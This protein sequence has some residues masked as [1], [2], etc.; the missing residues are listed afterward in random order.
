VFPG[1][2]RPARIRY[3]IG[4]NPYDAGRKRTISNLTTRV[5]GKSDLDSAGGFETPIVIPFADECMNARHPIREVREEVL[6]HRV[7]SAVIE[8]VTNHIHSSTVYREGE[9]RTRII[10]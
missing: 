3:Q 8:I 10:E 2:D 5:L 1:S 9:V 6:C 4:A 7:A